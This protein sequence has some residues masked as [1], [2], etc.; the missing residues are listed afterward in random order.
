[1]ATIVLDLKKSVEENASDYFEKAKK[2]K[3]KIK[4]AEEAIKKTSFETI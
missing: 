1:M 3:K 2:M 4:G